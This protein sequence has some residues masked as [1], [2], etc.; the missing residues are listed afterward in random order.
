MN[1]AFVTRFFLPSY[2]AGVAV[3]TEGDKWHV[4]MAWLHTQTDSNDNG[5]VDYDFFGIDLGYVVD[6]PFGEGHIHLVAQTTSR[7]FEDRH[8]ASKQ[9]SIDGLSISLDQSVG[10]GFAIFL[11]AGSANDDAAQLIHDALYSAGFQVSGQ[12]FSMPKLVVG[13]AYAYLDGAGGQPEDIR[14]T[15][16]L[17]TYARYP[18]A[19]FGDISA[20]VQW[21]SDEVRSAHNPQLWLIGTRL[22]LY[23]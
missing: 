17:E 16:V 8:N 19:D 7:D 1:E 21:V 4:D 15:R 6:L 23:F 18:I 12:S 22:N 2:D 5:G 14:H 11:R 10:D 20:D 9:T 3:Q 13:V